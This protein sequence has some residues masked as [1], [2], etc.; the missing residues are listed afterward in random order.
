MVDIFS[1]VLKTLIEFNNDVPEKLILTKEIKTMLWKLMLAK[2]G[3]PDFESSQIW[4][5][6]SGAANSMSMH[7]YSNYYQTLRD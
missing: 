1:R 7:H 3:L 5:L 2:G 6:A 4:I